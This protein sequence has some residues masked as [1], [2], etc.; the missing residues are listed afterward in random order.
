[1]ETSNWV[2]EQS[3]EINKV[4]KED[5]FTFAHPSVS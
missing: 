2:H 1:M 4:K 5:F 3:A